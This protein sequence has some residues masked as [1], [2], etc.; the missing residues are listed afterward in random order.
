MLDDT[1]L[2]VWVAGLPLLFLHKFPRATRFYAIYAVTFIVLNQASRFLLHECFL[3]T[4]SCWLWEHGGA[5]PGS[6][7]GEW[8]TVRIAR[9]VFQLAPSHRS[10]TIASEALIFVSAVGMLHSMRRRSPNGPPRPVS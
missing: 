5:P 6:V 10:I 8:F 7:P 1:D 9:A 3:T 4:I 2:A